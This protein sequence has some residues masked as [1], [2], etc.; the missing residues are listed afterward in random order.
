MRN[1]VGWIRMHWFPLYNISGGVQLVQP[2]F[3]AALQV[4]QVESHAWK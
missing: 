2:V 1:M 4:A 3:P